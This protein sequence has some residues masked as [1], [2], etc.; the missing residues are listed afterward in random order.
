M[1]KQ[2]L[3]I[4][5]FL[6]SWL[7]GFDSRYE[8][9]SASN[10]DD[11][12]VEAPSESRAVDYTDYNSLCLTSTRGASFSGEDSTFTPSVRTVISSK[13]VQSSTKSNSRIVKSGKVVDKQNSV[14]FLRI[15]LN[16]PSGTFCLDRYIYTIRHLLI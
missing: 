10:P 6:L 8:N 12:I 16:R 9:L 1:A 4:L 15:L 5:S 2:A 7:F 14:Y 13:R 11:V 3:L